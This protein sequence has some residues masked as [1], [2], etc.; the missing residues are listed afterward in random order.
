MAD[1]LGNNGGAIQSR[2]SGGRSLMSGSVKG[3]MT[4]KLI[5]HML[6]TGAMGIAVPIMLPIPAVAQTA[7][8]LVAADPAATAV[9]I[10]SLVRDHIAAFN[11]RDAIGATSMQTSDYLG[12]FHGAPN[13]I[14]HDADLAVTKAQVADPAMKLVI[15]NEYVDV[16]MAGD[17]ATWRCTYRYTYTDP[18]TKQV[19]VEFGNYIIGFRRQPDGKMKAAWSVVSD[20]PP[21]P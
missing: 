3:G 11:A 1:G 13:T 9:E 17:M 4:M 21:T 6:M 18:A 15:A 14:G 10:K 20:T 2:K 19:R 16:A 8:R 7:S 5:A 12:F